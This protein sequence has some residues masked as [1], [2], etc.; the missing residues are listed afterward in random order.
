[1]DWGGTG[2]QRAAERAG[3][4]RGAGVLSLTEQGAAEIQS[5]STN[6]GEEKERTE[7]GEVPGLRD[8][9]GTGTNK[10]DTFRLELGESCYHDSEFKATCPLG[11]QK[12]EKYTQDSLQY[13]TR[14]VLAV[15]AK[16]LHRVPQHVLPWAW[17][18][19]SKHF[20]VTETCFI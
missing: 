13:S 2:Q 9:V 4:W 6:M 10:A 20:L 19:W 7:R 14:C 18:Q 3:E 16:C 5:L 12:A 15:A 17:A 1:M 8:K 11:I